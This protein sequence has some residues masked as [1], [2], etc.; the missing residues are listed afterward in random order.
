METIIISILGIAVICCLSFFGSHI[1]NG[2]SKAINAEDKSKEKNKPE[3]EPKAIAEEV[4]LGDV[5]KACAFLK[6]QGIS[7]DPKKTIFALVY[8]DYPQVFWLSKVISGEYYTFG[9]NGEDLKKHELEPAWGNLCSG[10][11]FKLRGKI[12]RVINDN[13]IIP[14]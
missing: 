9:I 3:P 8:I 2:I 5:P 4:F 10:E 11:R 13:L 7:P 12:Y 14:V 1:L 6:S